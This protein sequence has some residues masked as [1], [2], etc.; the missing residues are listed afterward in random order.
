M[1]PNIP[2]WQFSGFALS[3][4]MGTLLHFMYDWTN[5]SILIAPFSGVNESTWEHMKLLYFPLLIFAIIQ[6]R[7]FKDFQNFWCIKLIGTLSGLISIPV[8][9]YTLNGAF[10]KTPDFINI[11]IFFISALI[12]F[13][14]EGR[15]FKKNT[16]PCPN[17]K[18]AFFALCFIG[19]LFLLF[20]FAT[21]K[22]PIFKDPISGSYGI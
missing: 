19:V 9:F 17:P 20:T 16:L 7:F 22:I 1:K 14:L 12:A 8:I 21:P 18:A 10:G 6:S 2:L 4:L 5:G 11:G 3:T 15:L 13:V